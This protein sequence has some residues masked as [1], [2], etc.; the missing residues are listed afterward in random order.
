VA[1]L[2]TGAC[3]LAWPR[4]S[5]L[6][7]RN[8]GHPSGDRV[9]AWWFVLLL[10]GAFAAYAAGIVLVRARP[11]RR[12]VVAALACGVQLAPLAAPLLL[13]TDAWAY[14]DY[15]RLAAV[16][17]LN[18]Y[19]HAPDAAPDDPA[20]PY[21]GSA[22]RDSISV[23]GPA[24][25]LVSEPVALAAGSSADAAAWIYKTLAAAAVLA[26]AYLASRLSPRPVLAI[27]F[28]GWNPLLA[29]HFG[30]GGHNDSWLAA[31]VVGALACGAARR[32]RLAGAC[33]AL[34]IGVKWIPLALLPLRAVQARATGRRIDH[35][36]LLAT[37]AAVGALATWRY[38]LAWTHVFARL[39]HNAGVETKFALPHRLTQLG[40][41]HGVSVVAFALALLA[42]YVI[43]LR[44][45]A[46]GANVLALATC[47]LLLATPYLTV[48]YVVWALPL[49]A[50][51]D[52]EWAGLLTFALGAYLLQQTIPL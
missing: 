28:V 40:V 33:W 16:H 7:P 27:A 23:Y 30:G 35:L 51:E 52:D 50:A 9:W 45:A 43:L 37:A 2:V 39:F 44:R 6:E 18:P 10:L 1:V 17:E 13:S 49:A 41:P 20:F 48:W 19:E 26:A 4:A 15:G 36:G 46:R 3:L 47:G 21:V 38:G 25:T 5:P 32:P 29:V 42:F 31:L 14:W 8:A 34:A 12:A 22:W 24:F 11:P